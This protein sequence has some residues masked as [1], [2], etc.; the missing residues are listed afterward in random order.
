M[1]VIKC[2]ALFISFIISPYN[3]YDPIYLFNGNVLYG[4]EMLSECF[5]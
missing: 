5:L 1:K 2:F 4:T 3:A